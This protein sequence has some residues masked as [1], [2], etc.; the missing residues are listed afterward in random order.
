M[1]LEDL[2]LRVWGLRV[3]GLSVWGLSVWFER[4]RS[5]E[6]LGKPL[7]TLV[8]SVSVSHLLGPNVLPQA[9]RGRIPDTLI[10]NNRANSVL[11]SV[12]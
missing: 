6:N 4:F 9:K 7:A 10:G 12:S 1:Q 8:R 11:C 3:W 5:I 2:G